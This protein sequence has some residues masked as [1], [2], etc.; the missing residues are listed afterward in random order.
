MIK[1]SH[2]DMQ[3]ALN[4]AEMVAL[5]VRTVANHRAKKSDLAKRRAD[6]AARFANM[7]DNMVKRLA[8]CLARQPKDQLSDNPCAATPVLDQHESL[9]K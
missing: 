3:K 4:E 6:R 1:T 8:E 5:W 9:G 2:A 7:A